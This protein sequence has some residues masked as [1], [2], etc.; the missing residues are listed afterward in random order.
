MT[1]T[2]LCTDNI[3]NN[4]DQLTSIKICKEK[5]AQISTPSDFKTLEEQTKADSN[6]KE[7]TPD[8]PKEPAQAQA[9]K[10]KKKLTIEECYGKKL[11]EE[12]VRNYGKYYLS[13][14]DKKE[15][16]LPP[17][18]FLQRHQIKSKLRSKMVDWMLEVFHACNSNEETFFAAVKIMDKFLWK[19]E[20]TYTSKDMY[21][22]GVCC[23]YIASKAND[24]K[25]ILMDK[26]LHCICHDGFKLNDIST[27]EREIILA[28]DFDIM[29]PTP[30]E[31][32]SFLLYDFFINNK[33]QVKQVGAKR[34]FEVIENTATWLAKMCNV[35]AE[36]SSIS[37]FFMAIACIIIGYDIVKT[38]SKEIGDEAKEYFGEWIRFVYSQ[39]VTDVETKEKI[40]AL[41]KKVGLS[42]DNFKL[43]KCNNLFL[44]H[45]LFFD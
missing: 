34:I 6:K 7:I 30:Y 31:M 14:F 12:L 21:L 19:T 43:M 28:L 38:N 15:L 26:L 10:E 1:E 17:S 40:E 36:F 29:I 24:L 39:I 41:Y 2:P 32:I 25:P 9:P 44:Y 5:N 13:T 37:P 33:V 3:K 11:S 42:Y 23:I 16:D 35:F 8:F 22:I 20:K 45:E 18:D 27:M 4:A